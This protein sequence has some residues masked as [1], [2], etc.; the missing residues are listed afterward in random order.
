MCNGLKGGTF[1]DMPL[2]TNRCQYVVC[3]EAV[4]YKKTKEDLRAAELA[5]YFVEEGHPSNN[6]LQGLVWVISKVKAT[7]FTLPK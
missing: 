2:H 7:H 3:H 4:T 1:F 6:T 5:E